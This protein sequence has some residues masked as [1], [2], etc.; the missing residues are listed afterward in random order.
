MSVLIRLKFLRLMVEVGPQVPAPSSSGWMN[1]TN[2]SHHAHRE[3]LRMEDV[4]IEGLKKS[5][6]FLIFLDQKVLLYSFSTRRLASKSFFIFSSLF[7]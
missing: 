6:T 3:H 4:C 1:I 7:F 2:G 5:V